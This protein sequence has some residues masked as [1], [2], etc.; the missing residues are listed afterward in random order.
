MVGLLV[1]AA[2]ADDDGVLEAPVLRTEWIAF[3]QMPLAEDRGAVAAAAAI[4]CIVANNIFGSGSGQV[5]AVVVVAA[6]AGGNCV[7]ANNI[8]G[9]II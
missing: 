7:V 3:A 5:D 2:T 6:A 9:N 8:A 4:N 1:D